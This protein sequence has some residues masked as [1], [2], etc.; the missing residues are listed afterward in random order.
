MLSH[1]A[2]L[3]L[4]PKN[5]GE[6]RQNSG[7]VRFGERWQ[8][9]GISQK[10]IITGKGKNVIKKPNPVFP[11]SVFNYVISI[12]LPYHRNLPHQLTFAGFDTDKIK[13]F[14]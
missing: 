11:G 9:S 7:D 13:T 4:C 12:A 2:R 10:Q 1:H 3:V 8:Q 6:T 14:R 5:H